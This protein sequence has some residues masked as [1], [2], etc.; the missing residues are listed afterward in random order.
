MLHIKKYIFSLLLI[1]SSNL[2]PAGIC[3]LY[4]GSRFGDNLVCYVH[5]KWLS[6]ITGIPFYYMPFEYSDQLVLHT[7]ELSLSSFSYE[8]KITVD[9]NNLSSLDPV[10]NTL[11]EIPYFPEFSADPNDLLYFKV[12]WDNQEFYNEITS[13]IKP[14]DESSNIKLPAD[15]ISVAVHVRKGGG[16]D[17]P[18]L[19]GN[20]IRRPINQYADVRWPLRFPPNEFYIEQLKQISEMHNNPPLYVYIFTDDRNPLLL[21]QLFA[22]QLSNYPN[23]T[24]DCRKEGNSHDAHV[25]EDL[26]AMTKFDCLIHPL[27]NYSFMAAQLA[28]Y[29]V[30]IFPTAS[31]WEVNKL[32][33]DAVEIKIGRVFNHDR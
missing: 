14:L 29:K 22:C 7:K 4:Q 1:L 32:F 26:F 25:V 19:S 30:E 10:L 23:I 31:H 27:S 17:L 16:F 18:L 15:C 2:Y 12:N 20:P 33:I 5:A 8:D 21:T 24:F 11:Y 3:N 9:N 13:L 28:C 6:F